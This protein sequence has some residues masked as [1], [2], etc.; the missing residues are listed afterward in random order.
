LAFANIGAA[1]ADF[2]PQT[3]VDNFNGSGGA[4][5]N[6][7]SNNSGAS[8]MI[9]SARGS[10]SPPSLSA[11]SP[12][13]RENRDD[14]FF[15]FMIQPGNKDSNGFARLSYDA[16]DGATRNSG[17]TAITVGVAWLYTQYATGAF[18][19]NG[20][21]RTNN[22]NVRRTDA[23]EL[24]A[25]INLLM[26]GNTAASGNKFVQAMLRANTEAT[27]WT[28]AYN[29]NSRYNEIGDYAVFAMN[30]V[31]SSGDIVAGN[32]SFLYVTTA[33]YSSMSAVPEPASLLMWTLGGIG[34]FGFGYRRKVFKNAFA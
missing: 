15:S 11:Y 22:A 16:T 33:N 25:A 34:A 21:L 4:V 7:S 28:A 30:L 1:L 18:A 24:A 32:Q 23:D 31:N 29:V 13:A 5:W 3:I 27:Y 20:L 10:G 8:E 19:S 6:Y 17:N 2:N 9:F 26:T 12:V 14:S